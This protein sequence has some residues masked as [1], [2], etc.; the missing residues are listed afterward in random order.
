MIAVISRKPRMQWCDCARLGSRCFS[1]AGALAVLLSFLPGSLRASI[2]SP[3]SLAGEAWVD[4]N[5]NGVVDTGELPIG[6]VD[7]TLTGTTTLGQSVLESMT[8]ATNGTYTFANLFAG[9][10][11]L[12]EAQPLNFI[13]GKTSVGTPGGTITN[14]MLTI[15]NIQLPAG[16][17]GINNN[18]GQLGLTTAYASKQFLL[19][20]TPPPP[21]TA[22][23][24]PV[25]EPNGLVLMSLAAWAIFAVYLARR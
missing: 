13:Q 5:N 22:V 19:F 12:T 14:N 4:S 25:P 9:T 6:G 20:P 15:S 7:I 18:F 10:Y 8:T 1:A 16:F 24:P 2:I 3:S 23:Y 17:N 21:L 11:A